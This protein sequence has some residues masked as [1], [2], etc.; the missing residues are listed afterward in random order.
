VLADVIGSAHVGL[1]PRQA[2]D[3][4]RKRQPFAAL[5]VSVVAVL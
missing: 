4:A 1:V 3:Q 2:P 5:A